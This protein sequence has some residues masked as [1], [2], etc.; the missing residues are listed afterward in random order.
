DQLLL[1]A[2]AQLT[3]GQLEL[4][5]R[6]GVSHVLVHSGELERITSRPLAASP[7]SNLRTTYVR[8]VTGFQSAP[9]DVVPQT[10][11]QGPESLLHEV[12]RPREL[13]RDPRVLHVFEQ[14]FHNSLETTKNVFAE[15]A[16]DQKINSAVV[17]RVAEQQIEQIVQD[18]DLYVSLGVK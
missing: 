17:T 18:L 9:R 5:K 12:E 8:P 16:S 15:F 10:W 1:A 4:L 13:Q 6:R 11:K 14:T 2:G 7:L 3:K